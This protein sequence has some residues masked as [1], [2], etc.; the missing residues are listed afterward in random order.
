MCY[1]KGEVIKGVFS[2]VVV[3]RLDPKY[4]RMGYE[5]QKGLVIDMPR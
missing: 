1:T 4:P 3:K 5:V 2:M